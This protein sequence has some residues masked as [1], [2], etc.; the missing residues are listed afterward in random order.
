MSALVVWFLLVAGSRVASASPVPH[1]ALILTNAYGDSVWFESA[2]FADFR[3]ARFEVSPGGE[4]TFVDLRGL[5][6]MKRR[7]GRPQDLLDTE[8]LE[9]LRRPEGEDR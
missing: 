7:A 8:A 9:S 4:A 6:D 5:I 3:A 1:T 2:T